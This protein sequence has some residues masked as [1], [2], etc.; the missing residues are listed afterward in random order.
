MQDTVTPQSIRHSLLFLAYIALSIVVLAACA[1][2]SQAQIT[3]LTAA[4]RKIVR[5]TI[6]ALDVCATHHQ[7]KPLDTI[8]RVMQ[9]D[10]I[11]PQIVF[12]CG[13]AKDGIQAVQRTQT[14]IP[15]KLHEKLAQ[16]SSI[17]YYLALQEADRL[18]ASAD[19]L[20]KE[21]GADLYPRYQKIAAQKH[22][23]NNLPKQL[24]QILETIERQHSKRI[25][26]RII[27]TKLFCNR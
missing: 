4:D 15:S 5:S 8:E 18:D 23:G 10:E 9:V 12:I 26:E 25:S 20:Q 2:P 21:L 6:F 22:Q 24:C 27:K 13:G 16:A 1:A 3:T 7:K 14:T 11:L 17:A 19:V